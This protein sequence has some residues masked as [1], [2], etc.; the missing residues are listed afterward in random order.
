[1]HACNDFIGIITDFDQPR[2]HTMG[3]KKLSE[4]ECPFP[5]LYI[6]WVNSVI[7]ARMK[8]LVSPNENRTDAIRMAVVLARV[9]NG[10]EL[11]SGPSPL[12]PFERD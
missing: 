11:R 1:M 6:A 5:I 9:E 8:E 10:R 2:L 12:N 7:A 4:T 3:F